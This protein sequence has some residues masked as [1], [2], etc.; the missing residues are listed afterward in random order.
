MPCR[1]ACPNP[2]NVIRSC[3]HSKL[4]E[5]QLPRIS[6]DDPVARYFGMVRGQVVKI[7]RNSETAGRYVTYRW[8]RLNSFLSTHSRW[9]FFPAHRM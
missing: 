5:Q 1:N 9:I 4:K 2:P 8:V 3:V 7:I 6:R